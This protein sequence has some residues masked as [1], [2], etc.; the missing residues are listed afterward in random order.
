M[1]CPL[2]DELLTHTTWLDFEHRL[3]RNF[4]SVQYFVLQ[5]PQIIPDM[6]MDRLNEQFLNYQLL[7]GDDIPITVKESVG[8]WLDDPHQ[9][10]VLGWC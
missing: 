8:L 3:E 9:V 4:L 6:N 7:K 10:D 1:W 2:N 5:Y